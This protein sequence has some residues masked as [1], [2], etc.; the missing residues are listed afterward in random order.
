MHQLKVSLVG[1]VGVLAALF[2]I[3]RLDRAPFDLAITPAAVHLVTAA[4]V[5]AIVATRLSTR[6][7]SGALVAFIAVTYVAARAFV[8]DSNAVWSGASAVL[9]T[10][11]VALSSMAV[12]LAVRVA[13]GM[14]EYVDSVA[15][16]TLDDVSRV[17]TL[18]AAHNDI[19]IEMSRARRHERPLTVTVLSFDPRA[20]HASLHQIVRDVQQR[21]MQRYIMSG[22]ARVTAETT[23]RG[24]IV[25][26]DP[27]R[28]RV[29]VLSPESSPGQ[30]EALTLR[31]QQT[32]YRTLGI[33]VRFGSAGFPHTALTFDDLVAHASGDAEADSQFA[34]VG[35]KRASSPQLEYDSPPVWTL[36]QKLD[37]LQSPTQ[38]ID[39]PVLAH[40]GD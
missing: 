21:M 30:L 25:V 24:D 15:N 7:P 5:I 35:P 22:L 4:I 16:I 26:Q 11:E 18:D 28:N 1:L 20:V 32:A 36:Y 38:S 10:A 37:H 40:P 39:D 33:P 19:A 6:V 9:T 34:F 17:M 27:A 3:G 23:R 8:I 13:Q 29:I 31:L 2:S 12:L 14:N